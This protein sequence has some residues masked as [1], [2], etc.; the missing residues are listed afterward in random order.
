MAARWPRAVWLLAALALAGCQASGLSGASFASAPDPTD[1]L[2]AIPPCPDGLAATLNTGVVVVFA[3]PAPHHP[4]ICLRRMNGRTYRY[5]L[6]FWGD[7][8]FHD[9][10]PEERAA[11][12]NVL[13]GPVGT[14]AQFALRRPSGLALWQS[15]TVTHLGDPMLPVGGAPHRTVLLRIQRKGP[16]GRA[17]LGTE[18]LIWLDRATLVPLQREEV[19][20]M[21]HGTDRQLAWQVR[22]LV[23]A[24][25]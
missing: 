3:G 9:G 6:G 13:T 7:G 20:R 17:D 5:F 24:S 8:R 25:D 18:S 2:A 14:S 4:D 10:T 16:A 12:R 11:I 22:A 23:P 19:V 15:A 21:A 1:G